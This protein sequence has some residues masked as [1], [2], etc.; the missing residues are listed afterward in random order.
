M[1]DDG[2][3]NPFFN[4]Y[5]AAEHP[6]PVRR[7]KRDA[8]KARRAAGV[9]PEIQRGGKAPFIQRG[10]YSIHKNFSALPDIDAQ[11]EVRLMRFKHKMSHK[12]AGNL[13]ALGLRP[14]M[15]NMAKVSLRNK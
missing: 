6:N 1:E 8:R 9:K 15:V 11:Y 10:G 2:D 7:A 3:F 5:D 12:Y 4:T 13:D 14:S